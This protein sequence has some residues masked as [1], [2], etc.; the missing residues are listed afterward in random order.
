MILL[1]E[2]ASD[3]KDLINLI[4]ELDTY[5]YEQYPADEVFA[6]DLTDPE[7]SDTIF[8]VAYY[9]DIAVGCG[10]IRPIAERMVELKRFYVKPMY[11][12]QGIASEIINDLESKA[13]AMSHTVIRLETGAAQPESLQFYAK[14]GYKQIDRYGEYI[15]NESSLCYEK[16]LE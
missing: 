14:H 15:H 11:R 8:V 16:K 10:A 13:F 12:N 4:E 6:L 7:I 9:N 1:H 5:L 2:V 3:N